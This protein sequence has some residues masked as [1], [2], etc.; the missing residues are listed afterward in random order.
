M[1]VVKFK[2]RGGSE[3][4]SL[5]KPTVDRITVKGYPGAFAVEYCEKRKLE[6]SFPPLRQF[7]KGPQG[8]SYHCEPCL[9]WR[10]ISTVS[11]GE[12]TG[13]KSGR[14]R[15]QKLTTVWGGAGEETGQEEPGLCP[16][17]ERRMTASAEY[18]CLKSA[19][20][21]RGCTARNGGVER[22]EG[23][24]APFCSS[25]DGKN[26]CV[27]L[28]EEAGPKLGQ[29]ENFPSQVSKNNEGLS[30]F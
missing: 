4:W 18:S 11:A 21:G 28:S 3:K 7:L 10:H 6:K 13:G 1:K 9:R 19:R 23:S 17:C 14:L 5:Y 16:V 26:P 29:Q 27:P 2:P 30:S 8:E 22:R 12:T 24:R 25:Q 20:Y 15:P